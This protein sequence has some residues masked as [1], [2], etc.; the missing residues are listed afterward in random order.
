M[1]NMQKNSGS[2]DIGTH[3]VYCGA[4]KYLNSFSVTGSAGTVHIGACDGAARMTRGEAIA[5]CHAVRRVGVAAWVVG[6]P[7]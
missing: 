6:V 1:S 5:A 3:T 4:G 2:E 7:A